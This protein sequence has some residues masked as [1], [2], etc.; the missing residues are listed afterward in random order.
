MG[1]HF[2]NRSN[3]T[4][5]ILIV[6]FNNKDSLRNHVGLTNCYL[7]PIDLFES[8]TFQIIMVKM[9]GNSN[10]ILHSYCNKFY[11][12]VMIVSF[13]FVKVLYRLFLT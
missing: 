5:T 4:V 1:T 13:I 10:L 9:A 12:M 3:K 6:I 8:S 11:Y 2:S 7:S